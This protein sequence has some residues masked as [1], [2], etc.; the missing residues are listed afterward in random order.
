MAVDVVKS[1]SF[2][3]GA[4]LLALAWAFRP[5]CEVFIRGRVCTDARLQSIQ[6]PIAT[7][8]APVKQLCDLVRR[9]RSVAAA[10]SACKS[11]FCVH[12]PKQSCAL[13]CWGWA[14]VRST[15]NFAY[16]ITV[17]DRD[18]EGL[19]Q[20]PPV[21][22]LLLWR[23]R[24]GAAKSAH[25]APVQLTPADSASQRKSAYL[26]V[27]KHGCRRTPPALSLTQSCKHCTEANNMGNAPNVCCTV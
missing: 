27:C 2:V 11:V 7:D 23:W 1:G 14:C 16:L 5:A 12:R 21:V 25:C 15:G 26:P 10:S 17:R 18:S 9:F 3:L 6:L 8:F 19:V 4:V 22:V 24:P 13:S 20:R